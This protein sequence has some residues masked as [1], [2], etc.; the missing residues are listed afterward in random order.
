MTAFKV[1]EGRRDREARV[2][3]GVILIAVG[4]AMMG[5][6]GVVLGVIGLVPLITGLTGWCPL[7]A[8]FKINTC[9]LMRH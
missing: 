8:L 2:V 3:A 9:K 1:N 5:T 7:Y 4:I 6:W